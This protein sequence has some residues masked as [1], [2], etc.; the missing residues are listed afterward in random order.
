[1]RRHRAKWVLASVAVSLVGALIGCIDIEDYAPSELSLSG[2]SSTLAMPAH[3]SGPLPARLSQTGAFA[4]VPTLAP[5]PSLVPYEVN[6]PFWS[7]GSMKRRWIALP[8]REGRPVPIEY[9]AKGE[10]KFPVGTVL[11]KHFEMPLHPRHPERSRRLET[12]ILVCDAPGHVYGAS[13][14]W[15]ADNSD[16]DLMTKAETEKFRIATTN[17]EQ[18]VAWTF[19]G[20]ED[21]RSCHSCVNWGVLGVNARQLHRT[22]ATKSGPRNQLQVWS[23]RGY[24]DRKLGDD[25]LAE[26]TPVAHL[27]DTG[28]SIEDRARSFLDVNCAYCHRPGGAAADFDARF[29]TPLA[30]QNLIDAPARINF[31]IDKARFIAPNDPWRSMVMLRMETLEPIKMP[32]SGHS[33]VHRE[34]A[35]LLADWIRSLP[36]PETL[37]PP[38]INPKGGDHDGEV[39]VRLLHP[40][41]AATLRYTLDGSA[42][43]A[44]SPAYAEPIVLRRSAT[45]RARAF[46]EGFTRSIPVHETFLVGR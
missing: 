22:I 13:Y 31:G 19:P 23:E 43:V 39:V 35:N 20:R 27:K 42:P 12:R 41:P 37:A 5:N 21:C 45:L 11:V 10:W 25:D 6:V 1:M 16:A 40:D 24:L 26:I 18:T 9:A 38:V 32:P 46:R 28:R 33:I 7:D 30:K 3:E 44:S 15:R 2:A 17:G 36:G 34:G 29:E 8:Q 14:K 4:N